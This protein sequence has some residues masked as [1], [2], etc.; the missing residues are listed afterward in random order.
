MQSMIGV[1]GNAGRSWPDLDMLSASMATDN[2]H[3]LEMSLWSIVRSP[4]VIGMDIRNK[5]AQDLWWYTNTE[6]RRI[7]RSWLVWLVE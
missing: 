3:L 4:L 5:T 1:S 6:V 7:G 2:D